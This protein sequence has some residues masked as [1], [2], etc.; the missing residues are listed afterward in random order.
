MAANLIDKE[1]TKHI[2]NSEDTINSLK[3]NFRKKT[4]GTPSAWANWQPR[5]S[6]L[7]IDKL[8]VLLGKQLRNKMTG[9]KGPWE[10]RGN[11]ESCI[12]SP[13]FTRNLHICGYVLVDAPQ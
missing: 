9:P 6:H 12:V 1:R 2:A 5:G 3:T 10:E 13:E 4:S 8:E 11:Q 7:R